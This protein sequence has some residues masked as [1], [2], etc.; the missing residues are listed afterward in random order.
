[1]LTD[2]AARLDQHRIVE[3]TRPKS[4]KLQSSDSLGIRHSRGRIAG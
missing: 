4:Y 2:R 1:M 3:T